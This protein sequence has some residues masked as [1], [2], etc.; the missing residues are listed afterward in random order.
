MVKI[1][2]KDS[3]TLIHTGQAN[4]SVL[5]KASILYYKQ[6]YK[7]IYMFK[8]LWDLCC[9]NAR[10]RRGR[11][12]GRDPIR[13]KYRRVGRGARNYSYVTEMKLPWGIFATRLP[14]S[15]TLPLA[16]LLDPSQIS[17]NPSKHMFERWRHFSNPFC[18]RLQQS[19]HLT[20]HHSLDYYPH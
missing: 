1:T 15:W 19:I 20:T 2:L 8:C 11:V 3:V 16:T 18:C 4:E 7:D 5:K 14:Y 6:G 10:E 17:S 12:W 9:F 13:W